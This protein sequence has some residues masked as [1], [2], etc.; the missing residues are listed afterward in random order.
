MCIDYRQLN[1]LTIKDKF[2]IPIIDD[3]L[4]ELGGSKLFSKLD[5]RSGYHQIRVHESDIPKTAFRTHH[6]HYEFK[7]MPF[8]LTNTPA[9]FQSVMNTVFAPY[10]R[11]FV[12]VFFDY[13]LVF[14]K[15]L[16]EHV[17]HLDTVLG[18][19]RRNK[20]YAKKRVWAISKPLTEL[21]SKEQF[22][23]SEGA[24][25]AF[26]AL[27]LAMTKAPALALPDFCKPFV[28][29]VDASGSGIGAVL[30]QE[31]RPIAYLSKA[32]KGKTWGCLLTKKNF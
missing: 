10:P 27:K 1:R 25:Q 6:G 17:K 31:G 21:L 32:I 12:L 26:E 5:L 13:I 20:L 18:E 19:L 23:W 3:L 2:P 4:D 15:N 16:E 28:L 14:S 11:K 7:V 9:T 30:S 24:Q 29:E 22:R 8:G